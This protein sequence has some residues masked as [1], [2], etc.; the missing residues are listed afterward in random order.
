MPEILKRIAEYGLTLLIIITLN[1]ALPRMM[2]GDPF[3]QLSG[4]DGDVVEAYTAEQREYFRTYYGLDRP[5]TEQFIV[6]IGELSRGD[7]GSSYYF[8]EAV[9]TLIFRR[10]P[11]TLFLVTAATILS[12]L[13]GLIIGSF[14][15]WRRG[16]KTE[17]F[18]YL[19][20][21]VLGEIPAFLVGLVLLIIFAAGLGWF[22]LSGAM[23]H[24]ARFDSAWERAADII[25]HAA[26]PVL[27]LA[28]A[29]SGSFFLLVRNSLGTVLT[30]DYMRTARAKGLSKWKLRWRHAMR[31]AMLP[32]ITRTGMQ[33]GAMVG[34]AVL[35]EN[36]FNY[37]GLGKLMQDA[38]FVRDYPLLQGIFLVL[39]VTVIAA[40][41]LADLLY[42]RL[43]P[44][45]TTN[46]KQ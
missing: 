10:L 27:T 23:T 12:L 29:R 39:A 35:V 25:Y 19:T 32:L 9:G 46:I 38:V 40:N 18:I 24:F 36:V 21:V 37:P 45:I 42:R 22:P 13:T 8:K 6:Y 44:R 5:V 28:L 41:L 15:A 43:D 20:M 34:G 7:L 11:W 14:A 26:L 4:A 31:N 3:M 2:P 1:F 16:R 30:R 33:A 17:R